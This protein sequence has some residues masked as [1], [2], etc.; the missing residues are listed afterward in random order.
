MIISHAHRF[1]F[2]KSL[3]TAG[4]SLEAA[5]S[6]HCQGAD[7]VTPL[8]DYEFNRDASGQWVHQAMNEGGYHQHDDAA[9]IRS[10]V[11]SEVWDGYFKFSIA[12][13]PW[14]RA[15]SYFFWDKRQDAALKPPKRL[16]HHLGVPFDD[17]SPVKQKFADFVKGRTLENNDRFYVDGD[18]L[19]VDFV[20]RYERLEDDCRE[21]CRRLGLPAIDIP[22]LKTGIRK[23]ERPYSDYY[24]DDTR[25][26]VAK[27]HANDIKFF[28]YR[29]ERA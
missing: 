24:D 4:T 6:R 17:F 21:L 28:D 3:K 22:Q 7:V 10:S 19:C 20:I 14:D 12:R 2:V 23:K 25:D 15:L 8:G 13:N 11:P 27:L 1:I 29:F 18:S 9:T 16:F 26:I 5:L